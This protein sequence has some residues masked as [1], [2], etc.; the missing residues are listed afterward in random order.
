[1]R[2]GAKEEG[3]HQPVNGHAR[4]DRAAFAAYGWPPEIP[5]QVI[6]KNLLALNRERSG[7]GDIGVE[8]KGTFNLLTI[9][10]TRMLFRCPWSSICP[11]PLGGCWA[12]SWP[13]CRLSTIHLWVETIDPGGET[14]FY[15]SLSPTRVSTMSRSRGFQV[16]LPISIARFPRYGV[17]H[18]LTS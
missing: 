7:E 17:L 14:S 6:L 3:I 8:G 13:R 11:S 1:M 2:G 5:D 18:S 4:L 15:S 16:G 9:V 12:S 10:S